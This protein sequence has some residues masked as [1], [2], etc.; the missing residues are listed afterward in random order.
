MFKKMLI[1]AVALSVAACGPSPQA[2][3]GD[4]MASQAVQQGGSIIEE[5]PYLT[6]GAAAAGG[7]LLAN[8]NNRRNNGYYDRGYGRT[9]VI[10]RTVIRR[11]SG[12]SSYSRPAYRTVTR[13]Y[14]R[15]R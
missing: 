12:Y 13:T 11:P 7:Y 9:R 4:A 3:Q 8:R 1:A 14:S 15:R 5:H 10:H 6:A 2:Y